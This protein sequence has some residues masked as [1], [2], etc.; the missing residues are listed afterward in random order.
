MLRRFAL[1]GSVLNAPILDD[2]P[3]G[4]PG[5]NS[6]G[7]RVAASMPTLAD[8]KNLRTDDGRNY[9]HGNEVFVDADQSTWRLSTTSTLT[10]DDYVIA[11]PQLPSAPSAGRWL[12]KTGLVDIAIP[13][14]FATGAAAVLWTVPTGCRLQLTNLYWEVTTS[15]AGGSSSAIGISSTKTGFDTPGDLLGGAAGD[16]EATLVTTGVEDYVKGTIGPLLDTVTELKA[17]VW[18][19]GDVIRFDRVT[20]VFTSGAGFVHICGHLTKN[21]GSA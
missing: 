5:L 16:V 1:I 15:W 6:S 7:A 13:I 3:Y 10:G 2:S 20:S 9:K 19:A 21:K 4:H 11:T 8:L 18:V 14:S 17:A 12:R